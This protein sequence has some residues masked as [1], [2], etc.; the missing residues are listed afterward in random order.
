MRKKVFQNRA[1]RRQQIATNKIATKRNKKNKANQA[2]QVNQ[3][4]LMRTYE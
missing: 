3:V 1:L 4:N 2:N